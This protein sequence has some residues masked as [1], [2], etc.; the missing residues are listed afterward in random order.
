M[1]NTKEKGRSWVISVVFVYNTRLLTVVLC[2][3]K[4]EHAPGTP[5]AM[6]GKCRSVVEHWQILTQG[7]TRRTINLSTSVADPDPKFGSK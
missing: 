7:N 3:H 4:L 1:R 5:Y 2:R 6:G